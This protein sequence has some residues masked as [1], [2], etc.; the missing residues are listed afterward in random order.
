[1]GERVGAAAVSTEVGLRSFEPVAVNRGSLGARFPLKVA[2]LNMHGGGRLEAIVSL[3]MRPPLRSAGVILLCEAGWRIRRARGREVAAELAARLGM[4]FVYAPSF[5]FPSGGA[6]IRSF[7]GNAI[8]SAEPL[9]DV[10]TAM[11]PEG[12]ARHRRRVGRPVGIAASVVV[13]GRAI[14]VGVAHLDRRCDPAF[15]ERQ[16]M[17]YLTAFPSGGPAVL[18]GDF[19]TTTIDM[20]NAWGILNVPRLM[21]VEPRRFRHP[22]PHEPLFERLRDAGFEIGGAN[23]PL[24]PTFTFTSLIP[25]FIRPKLDWIA[26]RGLRPVP[27]SAAVVAPRASSLSPRVSD[28]DFVVCEVTV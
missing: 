1:M 17:E 18:G 26:V 9:L 5:G 27:G 10:R 8:L 19:N 6:P 24:A 25:P 12:P 22:V 14:T 16:L 13:R 2:V 11:L 4:S 23:L 21:M 3:L 15:R 28:H 20:R 7:M